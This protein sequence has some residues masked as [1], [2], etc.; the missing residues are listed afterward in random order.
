MEHQ[1]INKI[2][3]IFTTLLL[4]VIYANNTLAANG[5]F[6]GIY[7]WYSS[8]VPALLPALILINIILT[9][10]NQKYNVVIISLLILA[11]IP[12]NAIILSDML[13]TGRITYFKYRFYLILS[14][15]P[16]L[17]F[18]TTYTFLMINKKQNI[19]PILLFYPF[20]IVILSA[21]LTALFFYIFNKESSPGKLV[22]TTKTNTIFS[23]KTLDTIISNS[24]TNLLKIL[25]YIVIFSTLSEILTLAGNYLPVLLIRTFIEMSC[26]ILLILDNFHSPQ[27]FYPLICCLCSFGGICGILQISSIIPKEHNI[28][29]FFIIKYKMLNALLAFSICYTINII[30]F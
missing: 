11:G 22:I 4:L 18:L 21:F 29:L 15:N 10:S 7:I 6:R 8:L 13:K 28:P 9:I 17:A 30:L 3:F 14:S 19:S 27:L 26:G 23:F 5:A 12:T 16:S 25:G 1:K 2:V 20:V 24:V